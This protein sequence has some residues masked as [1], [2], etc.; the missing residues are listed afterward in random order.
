[1]YLHQFTS[2]IFTEI[3]TRDYLP[4]VAAALTC[5]YGSVGGDGFQRPG[6]QDRWHKGFRHS[7]FLTQEFCEKFFIPSLL[8]K[9]VDGDDAVRFPVWV[10]LLARGQ[11]I[12]RPLAAI[13]MLVAVSSALFFG[14]AFIVR[15]APSPASLKEW[16]ND[17]FISHPAP[18]PRPPDPLAGEAEVVVPDWRQAPLSLWDSWES[19]K[20]GD[21]EWL[22]LPL[23]GGGFAYV[24]KA[25]LQPWK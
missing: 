15:N 20:V 11:F 1:M 3:G 12:T 25:S 8:G 10:Q 7:D 18:P 14:A 5:N 22:R 24:P 6:V 16:A 13:A 21:K 4:V 19:A 9:D 2:P 23:P 17:W